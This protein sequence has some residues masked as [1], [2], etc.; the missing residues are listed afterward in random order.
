MKPPLLADRLGHGKLKLM[1]AWPQIRHFVCNTN[2]DFNL[3]LHKFGIFSTH[4]PSSLSFYPP[5]FSDMSLRRGQRF[6][7]P[8]YMGNLPIYFFAAENLPIFWIAI[9]QICVKIWNFDEWNYG[10][11]WKPIVFTEKS[12]WNDVWMLKKIACG[13]SNLKNDQL[14]VYTLNKLV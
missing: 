1:S 13:A 4:Q 6:F 14:Q 5:F 8:I 2:P 11:P 9:F 7:K 10:L 12:H 3:H